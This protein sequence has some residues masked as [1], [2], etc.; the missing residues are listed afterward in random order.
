M[1]NV[2]DISKPYG[3]RY[4][5]LV[6]YSL[7]L[8]ILFIQL[9]I[10]AFFYNEFVKSKKLSFL[11]KQLDEIHSLENLTTESRRE[12]LVAQDY[13]HKFMTSKDE[14][15]LE[16]Y[17]ASLKALDAHL[18]TIN[19]YEDRFPKIKNLLASRKENFANEKDLKKLI[20]ST[21]QYTSDINLNNQS[22]LP[23]FEKFNLDYDFDKFNVVLDTKIYSDTVVK[24]GL[25]GRLGE[26]ISGKG[27]REKDSVVITVKEGV[28]PTS[29]SIKKDFDRIIKQVNN[30]YTV[31]NNK[32]KV[33][34]KDNQ[35][36]NDNFYKIFNDLFI[37]SNSLMNVYETAIKASKTD[38]EKEYE[39]QSDKNNE[40]RTYLVFGSMILMFVVSILIMLLTRIAFV[41]ERK[42]NEANLKI[43]ENLN[44]KNRILGMLS[45]ELRSPLKIMDIF[46]RRIKKKTNDESIQE[47]LKSI[48]FTNNTLL[49]QANQIL[50]YTK[51]QQINNKLNLVEF[52]LNEEIDAILNSIQPY[53]ETRNNNFV[54]E[55]NINPGLMVYSDNNKINQ[56]FMN[57]LGNANKFTE[58]GEIKV[59]TTAEKISADTA[60]LKTTITDTGVGI[61]K[62]DLEKIFEPYYQGVISDK[63]ENLGAGLGLSLCKELAELYSGFLKVDSEKNVG[64]KVEFLLNLQIKK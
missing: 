54:V 50:D 28:M 18:N 52:N 32:I 22:E 55:Q 33:K 60:V 43:K 62:S 16:S 20:D 57:I 49:I 4:R 10:A 58:N 26:A 15:F 53:I 12:L 46:I 47:Y 35:I 51:N 6:H 45:H 63:V 39:K 40:I 5:K 14:T 38:L 21:H 64:T 59:V 36:D 24:K 37:Y 31:Q 8:C 17:F 1:K 44:F 2:A 34:V 23:D 13:L 7:I 27:K 56:I 42:L 48:S 19:K 9:I 61:S 3:F 29:K 41:Y 25:F 30:H 11:Q